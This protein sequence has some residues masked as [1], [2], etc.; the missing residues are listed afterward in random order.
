MIKNAWEWAEK[1][2]LIYTHPV[3][4]AEYVKLDVDSFRATTTLH[5]NDMRMGV[6]MTV[7][8]LRA[9]TNIFMLARI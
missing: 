1:R 9:A 7:E 6:S 2:G 4:K 3:N 8:D 5:K